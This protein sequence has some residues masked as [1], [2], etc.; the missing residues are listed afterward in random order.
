MN[1]VITDIDGTILEQGKPVESVID[2][3]EA[4]ELPVY[5]LTNRPESDRANTEA[6]LELMDFDYEVLIMNGGSL[7][8]PD[9]KRSE[10]KA[11][12]DAGYDPQMFIDD[13][14]ANRDAVA[15]L[16]VQVIDPMD[17]VN[18]T[19]NSEDMK[20][21][22]ENINAKLT[23][24]LALVQGERDSL[25]AKVAE[26]TS[27]TSAL[28]EAQASIALLTSERDS[29]VAKVSELESA[30]ASAAKQAADMVAKAGASAPLAIT[31][32]V[33]QVLEPTDIL[34]Q[35]LALKGREQ[36]VFLQQNKAVLFAAR[37]A[38]KR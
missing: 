30:Q 9:F 16:G 17:V 3:V 23:A 14:K 38:G 24:D 28:A 19:S 13:S 34:A 4:Y 26:L 6:T 20:D 7:S 22:P 33:E 37:K 18:S 5:V 11:L 25:T 29:L 8:A 2:F 36:A 31:P 10:V 21:T 35:F 1:I 27:G 12:Q 15:E 32:K